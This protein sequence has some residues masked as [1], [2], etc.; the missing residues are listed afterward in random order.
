VAISGRRVPSL[1]VRALWSGGGAGGTPP[2][3]SF[4]FKLFCLQPEG[5]ELRKKKVLVFADF[6]SSSQ[7]LDTALTRD[8]GS[9]GPMEL[10]LSKRTFH[11]EMRARDEESRTKRA[12]PNAAP[13]SFI[14]HDAL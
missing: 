9:N 2:P 11:G 10:P 6:C 12:A 13:R 1:R 7:N 8:D 4:N 14:L 3:S 5:F